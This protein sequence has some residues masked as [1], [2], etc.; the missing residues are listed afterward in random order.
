MP[1]AP[2]AELRLPARPPFDFARTVES[3]IEVR[4]M[5][6]Y[7][8]LVDHYDGRAYWTTVRLPGGQVAGLEIRPDGP[9]RLVVIIYSDRDPLPP[10]VDCVRRTITEC[11]GLDEDMDEVYRIAHRHPAIGRLVERH[12]GLRVLTWQ[13]PFQIVCIAVL[14]QNATVAR[15]NSMIAALV[16][17]YGLAVE[18]AG[19]NLRH[20]FPPEHLA[21]ADPAVLR[22]ECRLGFRAERLVGL[23]QSIYA[24][25]PNLFRVAQLPIDEAR[26]ELTALKGIGEYSADYILL[27][28]RRWDAFPVDVW[29]ARQFHRVFFPGREAPPVAQAA[30]AVRAQADELW[31]AWRGLIWNFVLHELDALAGQAM[32]GGGGT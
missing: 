11:W 24:G 8:P 29:S 13:E 19:L 3:E 5:E 16:E 2:V 12:R 22:E 30:A 25:R 21:G 28:L 7:P 26:S 1:F 4:R 6:G 23:A 9:D 31:G 17:R 18:F 32:E 15:T 27:G 10:E 20:W 14:L